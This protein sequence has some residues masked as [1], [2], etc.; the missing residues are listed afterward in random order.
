MKQSSNFTSLASIARTKGLLY[1][2]LSIKKA[3]AFLKRAK[4]ESQIGQKLSKM[5]PRGLKI[6]QFSGGG[7]PYP[8]G[9]VPPLPHL[10]Q[11]GTVCQDGSPATIFGPCYC[12]NNY[13]PG[14]FKP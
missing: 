11:L 10:L 9:G 5:Q 2:Y 1:F 8:P 14:Y 4:T 13:C 3:N 6:E 12:I 7:T